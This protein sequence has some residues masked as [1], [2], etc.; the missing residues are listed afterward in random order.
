M[1]KIFKNIKRLEKAQEKLEYENYVLKG[2][3]DELEAKV[4]YGAMSKQELYDKFKYY[5]FD[6]I[7][8]GAAIAIKEKFDI[9]FIHPSY[10]YIFSDT[11]TCR[12]DSVIG[13]VIDKY[14]LLEGDKIES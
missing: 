6:Q 3:V 5:Q 7:D 4:I 10:S 1:L 2:K 8:A 14:N 9:H 13:Q 11:A 12:K